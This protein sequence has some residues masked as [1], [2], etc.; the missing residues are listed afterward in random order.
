M[1]NEKVPKELVSFNPNFKYQVQNQLITFLVEILPGIDINDLNKFILTF[2]L[3][4]NIF[5]SIIICDCSPA[6]YIRND[7]SESE[8]ELCMQTKNF[9]EF[10][11][12]LFNK[13]VKKK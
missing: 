8:K 3:L 6:L 7:L 12:E 10:I 2:Q 5:N 13:F 11:H 1:P 9:D 4:T